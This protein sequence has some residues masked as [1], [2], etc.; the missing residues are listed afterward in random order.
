M[1]PTNPEHIAG[2]ASAI[3]ILQSTGDTE[4]VQI[5]IEE[6]GRMVYEQHTRQGSY[7]NGEML[8]D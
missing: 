3:L 5:L 4:A 8:R 6:L 2:Y 7:A 1:N